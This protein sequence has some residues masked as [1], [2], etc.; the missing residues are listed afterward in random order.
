MYPTS[1][2]YTMNYS[3][4]V[5]QLLFDIG[6]TVN[7]LNTFCVH[8]WP[9]VALQFLQDSDTKLYS[10]VF[11]YVFPQKHFIFFDKLV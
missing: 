8:V 10:S 1:D 11:K 6:N 5:V 7:L 9:K 3:C 2:G 4:M